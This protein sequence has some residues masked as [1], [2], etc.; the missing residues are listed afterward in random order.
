MQAYLGEG[1]PGP[2]ANLAKLKI[3][4]PGRMAGQIVMKLTMPAVLGWVLGGN[5]ETIQKSRQACCRIADQPHGF[6]ES[7]FPLFMQDDEAIVHAARAN[8]MLVTERPMNAARSSLAEIAT[9]TSTSE[10]KGIYIGE[11]RA[12]VGRSGAHL[13]VDDRAVAAQ[14][15][16]VWRT[17]AGAYSYDYHVQDLGSDSGE[18]HGSGVGVP[19]RAYGDWRRDRLA[20]E[21]YRAGDLEQAR[22]VG[23]VASTQGL[24]ITLHALLAGTWVNG[25]QLPRGGRAKLHPGDTLEF[26]RSPSSEVYK[27]KLQH[28][29]QHQADLT[30]SAF[31]RL[32]LGA[33]REE[34]A[35]AKSHESS[36]REQGRQHSMAMA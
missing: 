24:I 27:I 31:T 12:V 6:K 10:A 23:P 34:V 1:M 28:I 17:P 18:R 36:S 26:G 3:P 8:W 33:Q 7:S 25:R 20:A 5:V 16:H 35:A 21:I 22:P 32:W 29:T 15:A 19:A 30:G 4:H 11:E 9:D 2:L 14:H 13:E